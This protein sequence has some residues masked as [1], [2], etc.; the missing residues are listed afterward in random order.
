MS[1]APGPPPE[2]TAHL[3]QAAG[4]RLL[5]QI[6]SYPGK[7]WA[8]RIEV[9]LECIADTRLTGLGRK[10]LNESSPELWMRLFGPAG[11]VRT[12]AVAWEGGL[13]PGY[14]LAELAAYYGAFGYEPPADSAPDQLAVLLDFAAWL[15]LK[16]AY[17][18]VRQDREA[19]E[20]T[21]R[22]LETFL[23]RFVAPAAW[24]VYRQLEQ[25]GPDFLAEA[26]RLAAERSGAEPA[27]HEWTPRGWTGGDPLDDESCGARPD[28]VDIDAGRHG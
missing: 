16:L 7:D 4:W 27:A 12:R 25:T 10:A 8:A 21:Q 14:L 17:A 18:C 26:A 9:L 1:N 3:E 22:A 15:D 23:S 19:K 5:A 11:P 28:L 20:I 2:V 6:F 24:P 13:Q